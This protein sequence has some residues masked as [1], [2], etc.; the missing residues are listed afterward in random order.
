MVR[1]SLLVNTHLP[2]IPPDRRHIQRQPRMYRQPAQPL[3]M[4]GHNGEG[5]HIDV[6]SIFLDHAHTGDEKGRHLRRRPRMYS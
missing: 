1:T 5:R 3:T 4:K 2:T 6:R